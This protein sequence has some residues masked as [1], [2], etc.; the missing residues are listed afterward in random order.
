MPSPEKCKEEWRRLGY[1]SYLECKGYGEKKIGKTLSAPAKA[2]KGVESV[3]K[4]NAY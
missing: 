1:T 4:T 3:K 2:A